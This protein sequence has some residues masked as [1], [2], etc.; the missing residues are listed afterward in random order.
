MI[1]E[2]SLFFRSMPAIG[3]SGYIFDCGKQ[4]RKGLASQF[5]VYPDKPFTGI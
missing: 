1:S 5:I 3:Q 2:Y 4:V